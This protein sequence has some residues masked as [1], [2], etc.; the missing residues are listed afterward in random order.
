[1]AREPSAR[2]PENPAATILQPKCV[3]LGGTGWGSLGLVVTAQPQ[4]G[5]IPN[6]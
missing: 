6:P 4:R 2:R 3:R 1:V 5:V